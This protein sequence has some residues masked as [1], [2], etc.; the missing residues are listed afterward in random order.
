MRKLWD[1]R[2]AASRKTVESG[3]SQIISDLDK[4][5]FQ[6]AMKPVYAQFAGDAKLQALVKRI[7]DTK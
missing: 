4:K 1:D 7:Q 5:S 2:E 6:D 3:G